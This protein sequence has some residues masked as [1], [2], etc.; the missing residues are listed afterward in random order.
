M[1]E[2]QPLENQDFLS[3]EIIVFSSELICAVDLLLNQ[4]K[5]VLDIPRYL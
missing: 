4:L 1:S 3:Q 5:H 2:V